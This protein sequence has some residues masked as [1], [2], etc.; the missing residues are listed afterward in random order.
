M[1]ITLTVPNRTTI[2]Q[3]LHIFF[4]E[5]LTFMPPSLQVTYIYKRFFLLLGHK[6]TTQ[7]TLCPLAVF[8]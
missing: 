8:L 3:D 5:A 6:G 4:T 2:L 1:Q 7:L